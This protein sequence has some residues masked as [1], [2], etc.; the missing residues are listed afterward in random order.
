MKPMTLQ[1]LLKVLLLSSGCAR[2]PPTH[3]NRF[4]WR[5]IEMSRSIRYRIGRTMSRC[6]LMELGQGR[7]E[8]DGYSLGRG[9]RGSITGSLSVGGWL[10]GYGLKRRQRGFQDWRGLTAIG[11]AS[12]SR[13]VS[14]S[15][16]FIKR[17]RTAFVIFL[18]LLPSSSFTSWS[19]THKFNNSWGFTVPSSP[20]SSSSFIITDRKSRRAIAPTGGR[21]H[22]VTGYGGW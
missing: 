12:I 21:S 9:R 6:I 13:L 7:R 14:Q 8:R 1:P 10:M 11:P 5:S 22:H 19:G 17:R 4:R 20:S 15:S 2:C 3:Q 18:L 16:R